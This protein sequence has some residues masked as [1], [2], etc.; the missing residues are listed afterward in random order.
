MIIGAALALV[1]LAFGKAAE[2]ALRD[3]RD[4]RRSIES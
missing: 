4:I 1:W 3:Q 2:K